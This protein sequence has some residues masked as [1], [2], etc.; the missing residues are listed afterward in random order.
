MLGVIQQFQVRVGQV[1]GRGHLAREKSQSMRA[2]IVKL[3]A[4][5]KQR[6]QATTWRFILEGAAD[7]RKDKQRGSKKAVAAERVLMKM[8]EDQAGQKA[9]L[10]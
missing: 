2:G 7:S 1:A 8:M 10:E 6:M 5:L 9:I 3:L 4:E